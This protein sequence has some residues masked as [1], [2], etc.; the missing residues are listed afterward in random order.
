[1]LA[2][3]SNLPCWAF[4]ALLILASRPA[5]AQLDQPLPAAEQVEAGQALATKWRDA[6]PAENAEY[7]GA[8]KI[9]T[10]EGQTETV[11]LTFRIIAGQPSWQTIYEAGATSRTA[12]QKLTIIHT[13]GKANQYLFA[14]GARP[15]EAAGQPVQL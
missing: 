8:L 15:G 11:P 9:R 6:A 5:S 3:I 7:K 10:S 4:L 2:Q 1:M 12:V 13:P 14:G